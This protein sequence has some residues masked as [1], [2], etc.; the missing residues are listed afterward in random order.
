MKNQKEEPVPLHL[1][2]EAFLNEEGYTTADRRE[3]PCSILPDTTIIGIVWQ[4]RVPKI[5]VFSLRIPYTKI[6]IIRIPYLD[7]IDGPKHILGFLNIENPKE[8]ILEGYGQE[9]FNIIT[10][11][12]MMVMSV[13]FG[14]DFFAE[15]K[16]DKSKTVEEIALFV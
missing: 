14:V 11:P 9:F 10:H 16:E 8:W 13:K 7:F 15:L 4:E 1:Q 2:I 3:F 12:L 5:K 6:R